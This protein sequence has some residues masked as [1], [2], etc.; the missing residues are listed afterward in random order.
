MINKKT[1]FIIAIVTFLIYIFTIATNQREIERRDKIISLSNIPFSDRIFKTERGKRSKKSWNEL[2]QRGINFI[3]SKEHKLRYKHRSGYIN[4]FDF[5]TTM[6]QQYND[7]TGVVEK[8]AQESFL[9]KSTE[10]VNLYKVSSITFS[11]YIKD[12]HPEEYQTVFQKFLKNYSDFE[13]LCYDRIF[14]ENIDKLKT[15]FD[16]AANE[17]K[18]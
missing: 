10:L 2:K 7:F 8:L 3:G 13:G 1:I 11:T 9:Q 6:P 15:S 18:N 5:T 17:Q 12:Y 16:K 4:C 14:A